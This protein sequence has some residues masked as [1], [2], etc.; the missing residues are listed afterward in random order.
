M[1][2]VPGN[3]VM[4]NIHAI[5]GSNISISFLSINTIF[6]NSYFQIL[7]LACVILDKSHKG[8]RWVQY[9]GVHNTFFLLL[10][11]NVNIQEILDLL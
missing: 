1:Q 8:C 4:L 11:C 9:E 2:L 6:T 5:F 10:K 3:M 7:Y